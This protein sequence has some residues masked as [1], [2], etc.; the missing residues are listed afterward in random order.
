MAWRAGEEGERNWAGE[1]EGSRSC[2]QRE[3]SNRL[4]GETMHGCFSLLSWSSLELKGR[5]LVKFQV[6][7]QLSLEG[8]TCQSLQF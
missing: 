4:S 6:S 1:G 3:G 8:N 7:V 2:P 5:F